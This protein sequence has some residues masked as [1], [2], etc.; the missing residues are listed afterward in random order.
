MARVFIIVCDFC[1][2]AQQ[3]VVDQGLL[4]I[5]A[6]QSHTHTQTYKSVGFLWK[7]DQ[8]SAVCVI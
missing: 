8:P 6:S 7:S 3:P 1:P 2:M 5:E 4:V